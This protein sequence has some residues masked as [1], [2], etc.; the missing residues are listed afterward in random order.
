MLV[1]FGMLVTYG[2]FLNPLVDEFGW[3]RAA[4]S[5]AYSLS[6]VIAGVIGIVAGVLTDRVGPR[7]VVTVSGLLLGVG[8]VMMLHVHNLGELYV[9]YGVL[10]GI[11]MSGMWVPPISA[12][13]RWFDKRR[14][15]A[16]G[17]V[18]S[19]MTVGQVI[20]PP[21]ISRAIVGYGWRDTY[22]ILGIVLLA[23]IVVGAQF[24]RNGP[25]HGAEPAVDGAGLTT[26]H[27][28]GLTLAQAARTRQFWM[29][30]ATF[31]FC[32]MSAF[33]LLIHFAP[34]LISVGLSEV[35]AANVMAV[36]GA[37][38]IPGSFLLG[39]LVG[40]WLGDRKAFI[41]GLTLVFA[42]MLLIVP[43]RELWALYACG[44]VFGFGMSGMAASESPLIAGLFGLD[45]HGSIYSATGIGYTVGGAFGPLIF[46]WIFD[47]T[48]SYDLALYLGAGFAFISLALLVMLRPRREAVAA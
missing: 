39:G 40:Q 12:V 19:G 6:S 1:S 24:L 36:N 34:R 8:Y 29:I 21:I 22:L 43:A 32:G 30:G 18:L 4:V 45:H 23:I 17:I 7:I 46:G 44:V 41:A 5:G 13:A 26:P 16:T 2:L 37:V 42:A 9:Y 33:G 35:T 47:V 31:F 10:V 25:G 15:L 48:G 20:A 28:A 38:G 3:S 11:G 27:P 14:S